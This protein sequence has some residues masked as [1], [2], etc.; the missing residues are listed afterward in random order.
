[1]TEEVQT[2]N[3]F[4][5]SALCGWAREQDINNEKKKALSE[6]DKRSPQTALSA[7]NGLFLYSFPP[8]ESSRLSLSQVH[9]KL[10]VVQHLTHTIH[11]W[12]TGFF[13]VQAS[14]FIFY[15]LLRF[16]GRSRRF[17]FPLPR[18]WSTKASIARIQLPFLS[19]QVVLPLVIRLLQ[20]VPWLA[21][22]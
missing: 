22:N 11:S 5:L 12:V 16:L 18:P 8:L 15:F 7:S 17:W 13:V 3:P 20:R 21:F 14:L 19:A 1:V 4:A 10:P 9:R 2:S 6:R